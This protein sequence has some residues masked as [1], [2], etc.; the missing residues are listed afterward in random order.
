MTSKEYDT[1][2]DD[3]EAL[4]QGK[5]VELLIRDMNP[6][7]EKYTT[8]RVLSIVSEDIQSLPGGDILWIRWTRGGLRPKP[9]AIKIVRELE[10]IQEL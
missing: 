10:L 1:F 3:P 9:W 5:E 4:P 8:K 7:V 2:I 6:G